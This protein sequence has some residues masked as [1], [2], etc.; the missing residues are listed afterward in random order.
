MVG[1]LPAAVISD[2]Y[3]R[4]MAMFA[5][6]WLIIIG[7]VVSAT[8]NTI[9]QFTVGRFIL[10]YGITHMSLA[11]PAFAMEIAPPQW[12]GRCAGLLNCGWFGGSIPAAAIT[13]GTN[14]IQS[15][16]SWRIPVILQGFTCIV[17]ICSV[18]FV[19]E[20]PRWQ[21]A[22]GKEAEA[23]EFLVKYHGNGNPNSKLVALQIEEFREHIALDGADKTWWDCELQAWRPVL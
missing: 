7:T 11:A 22:N 10:G 4:R 14:Y 1:A 6:A 12:R 8:G 3:G 17:V 16:Y 20:S 19:P 15:D 13:Y 23:Y 18:F 9:A 21:M 2:R 5:G